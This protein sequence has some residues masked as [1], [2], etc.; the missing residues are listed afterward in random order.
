M[1]NHCVPRAWVEYKH[2]FGDLYSPDGEF[3]LGNKPLHGLTSQGV[4][5]CMCGFAWFVRQYGIVACVTHCFLG[6]YTL[7]INMED[8]EGNQ[9]YAEYKNFK[10]DDEKVKQ[11]HWQ[12]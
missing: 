3:W 2:G 8:F 10:V 9:R 4:C 6:N 7:R 12:H 5:L 1:Y 11:R